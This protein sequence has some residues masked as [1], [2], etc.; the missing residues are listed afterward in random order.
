[1]DELRKQLGD[2]ANWNSFIQ[3]LQVRNFVILE[4]I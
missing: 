2:V 3:P 4:E 1:M